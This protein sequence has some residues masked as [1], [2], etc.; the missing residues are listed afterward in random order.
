MKP[1]FGVVLGVV[2]IVLASVAFIGPWW[3][4]N[5]AGT[6]WRTTFSNTYEYR[7]LGWT[8][9]GQESGYGLLPNG[10]FGP[11]PNGTALAETTD[12]GGLP[13]MGSV[14]LVVAAF[15]ASGLASGVGMVALA[16]LSGSKPSLRGRTA[17]LGSLGFLLIMAAIIFAMAQLPS[18]ANQDMFS[19]G[20]YYGYNA[21]T[22]VLGFW[23]TQS[24]ITMHGSASF[25]W[26]AGWGWYAAI[27][28]AALFL[29]GGLSVL[30]AGT[31]ASTAGETEETAPPPP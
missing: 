6:F 15:E 31:A 25:T 2:G 12:Y 26:Q 27:A 28:A 22:L 3:V 24:A 17:I 19:N 7:L 8:A 5:Q 16:K 30:H 4:M 13:R 18:A 1:G 23:G 20:F 11:I 29:I 10:T 21:P 9:T 14:F